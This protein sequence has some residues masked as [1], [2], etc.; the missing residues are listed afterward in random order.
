MDY[1]LWGW[2]RFEDKSFSRG[3]VW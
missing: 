1:W 3:R 2:I